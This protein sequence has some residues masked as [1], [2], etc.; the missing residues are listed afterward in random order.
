ML[1]LYGRQ[2]GAKFN[3]ANSYQHQQ[4]L[5]SNSASKIDQF[6]HSYR[7]STSKTSQN[8]QQNCR[9]K[10]NDNIIFKIKINLN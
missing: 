9:F 2:N 1:G 7:Q 8:Q 6:Q 10:T 5:F 3:N 4:F